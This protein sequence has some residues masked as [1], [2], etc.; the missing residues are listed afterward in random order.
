MPGLATIARF[1]RSGF[2]GVLQNDYIAYSRSMGFPLNVIFC[3]YALKNAIV[4]TVTQ[5]GLIVG[6]L[7]AWP[8]QLLWSIFSFGLGLVP[9]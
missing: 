4:A 8:V 3:K 1:T 6:V 9:S 7:L 2:L 5:I